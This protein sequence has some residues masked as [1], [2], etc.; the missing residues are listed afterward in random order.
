MIVIL[1]KVLNTY[2]LPRKTF[3]HVTQVMYE[4]KIFCIRYAL[5]VE[6][7]P[8]SQCCNK[9]CLLLNTTLV[10]SSFIQ[11][12]VCLNDEVTFLHAPTHTS[13]PALFRTTQVLM[14]QIPV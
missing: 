6:Q 14:L 10:V 4:L 11:T 1:E 13:I 9:E 5:Q 12:G 7:T 2:V 3:T 8:C